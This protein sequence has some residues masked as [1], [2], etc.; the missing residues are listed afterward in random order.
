MWKWLWNWVIGRGWKSF[1]VHITKRLDYPEGTSGRNMDVKGDYCES[2]ERK[3]KTWTESFHL[4]R[5]YIVM[6]RILVEI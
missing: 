2:S 3:K 6:N 4:L 5:E 1:E